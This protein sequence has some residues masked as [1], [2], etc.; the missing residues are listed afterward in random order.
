MA[1]RFQ[2]GDTV[3]LRY[4]TRDGQPGMSWPYTVVRDSD[5][6]VALYIPE[7]ATYKNWSN[8]PTRHL[9]DA[10]WRR[11]TLR[12]MYPGAAHSIWLS[13]DRNEAGRSLHGYYVNFE[14]PF[15]RTPIGFDTNDH[16][17]DIVVEPDLTWSWKDADDFDRR[18]ATGVYGAEFAA[19]VREQ[20][21][22]LI[23]AIESRATPYCD[24]WEEWVP[25]PGWALPAL[26]AEWNTVPATLWERRHWA[27][28]E[29]ASRSG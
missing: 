24:G 14:E 28:R 13:W 20:A 11:D 10:H 21:K 23:E 25:D 19:W 22:P 15:R 18:V 17:L 6:L 4:I 29:A 12:L 9:A 16:M 8:S 5:E 1:N 3:A 7:G 27:Y 26:P 2:T